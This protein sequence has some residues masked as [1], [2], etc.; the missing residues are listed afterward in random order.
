MRFLNLLL[1][2]VVVFW[3]ALLVRY[4]REWFRY[5]NV[6]SDGHCLFHSLSETG[7]SI[8]DVQVL[9]V[10]LAQATAPGNVHFSGVCC[11]FRVLGCLG[12][13][14]RNTALGL[15]RLREE[16]LTGAWCTD[17]HMFLYSLVTG[18][19]VVCYQPCP[20]GIRKAYDTLDEWGSVVRYCVQTG[21]IP[22]LGVVLSS[23]SFVR[24]IYCHCCIDPQNRDVLSHNHFAKLEVVWTVP[25]TQSV[26]GMVDFVLDAGGSGT[27]ASVVGDEDALGT[28]P[29]IRARYDAVFLNAMMDGLVRGFEEPVAGCDVRES[30]RGEGAEGSG[31]SGCLA[32]RGEALCGDGTGVVDERKRRVTFDEES[33]RKRGRY[34]VMEKEVDFLSEETKKFIG[35]K[36]CL[37]MSE[38]QRRS[39]WYR[40]NRRVILERARAS[41]ERLSREIGGCSG[42]CDT[43]SARG[44]CY[45]IGAGEL[46]RMLEEDGTGQEVFADMSGNPSKAVLLHYLNSGLF[47]FGRWKEYSYE[48]AGQIMDEQSRS[49]LCEEILDEKLT[50]EELK[51]LLE[52]FFKCHSYIEGRLPSC[53][54]CG[55]RM[56]ERPES[57]EIRY[58]CLALTS[59]SVLGPLQYTPCEEVEFRR[60]SYE[61]NSVV[62]IPI[63]DK[64]D[65]RYVDVAKAESVFVDQ[66]E[67]HWHLH[68][69]LVDRDPETGAETTLICPTC[70]ASLKCEK[71]PDL[72]I[73]SGIDFGHYSRLGLTLPNIHE[74]LILSRA[75]LFFA[76]MKFSSNRKGQCNFNTRNRLKCHAILFPSQEADCVPFMTNSDVFGEKGLLDL[77]C[78][79]GM[80]S[81][82]C[83]DDKTNPDY[84]MRLI[85]GSDEIVGRPW[86]LAQWL[87]VL[88]RSNCY[89]GDIDVTGT[90]DFVR[91]IEARMEEVY[92]D[93]S[94]GIKVIN[95]ESALAHEAMLGSD[96]AENQQVEQTEDLEDEDE[97]GMSP[98]S[99]RFSYIAKTEQG[100]Y[101]ENRNDC[102]LLA[103]RKMVGLREEEMEFDGVVES[104]QRNR[105]DDES[106]VI[107]N[108]CFVRGPGEEDAS[109]SDR[110]D[111]SVNTEETTSASSDAT[112]VVRTVHVKQDAGNV[113]DDFAG[114]DQISLFPELNQED[115]GDSVGCSIDQDDLADLGNRVDGMGEDEYQTMPSWDVPDPTDGRIHATAQSEREG[116]PIS[117]FE[118][119]TDYERMMS[120]TFPHVFMLGRWYK[121]HPG[122]LSQKMRHHLLHQF[123]LTPAQDRRLLA[124]LFDKKQRI[125]VL[126]G[127]KAYVGGT[128]RSLEVIEELL[129][130]LDERK[131]LER[132]CK[133]PTSPGSRELL[134]KYMPHL[135][136]A[137]KDVSYGAAEGAKFQWR[138]MEMNKRFS[139]PNCFLTISPTT[140]D[141]PR[142]IRLAFRTVNNSS[143][144]AEFEEGC[145]YG[146]DPEDFIRRL[147][148]FTT[149]VS[150]GFVRLP[151]GCITKAERADLAMRNPVA[152][153]QENKTLLSDILSIL[154]GFSIEDEAF[155]GRNEGESTR[156][157]NYYKSKK[158]IFGHPLYAIGVTEDHHRG[159]LHWHVSLLAGV[160]PY[161][162]QQ[163][164]DLEGV[165]D[166]ISDVLDSMYTSE[167]PENAH[168]GNLLRQALKHH[169]KDE[170]WNISQGVINSISAREPL[171]FTCDPLS[172]LGR[173]NAGEGKTFRDKFQHVAALFGSY[174]QHHRHY[175]TCHKTVRGERGCRFDFP[176]GECEKTRG[177]GLIP[178]MPHVIVGTDS[179]REDVYCLPVEATDPGDT[180]T[181]T[182]VEPLPRKQYR[183]LNQDLLDSTLGDGLVI[184]E[185]K[186]PMIVPSLL[187][188]PAGSSVPSLFELREAFCKALKNLPEYQF[189]RGVHF[190]HWLMKTAT[191][192]QV[193]QLWVEIIRELPLGNRM[194]PSFNTILSYC[195]G[196]HN[197]ASLL[198]GLDQAKSALFYLVPYQGKSKFPIQEALPILNAAL[199]FV[200]QNDSKHPTESGT[201]QRTVK[202]L[203]TRTIN[204]MHL[205]MEI[206]DYEMAASL[207]GLPS[208][209]TSERFAVGNPRALVALRAKLKS[210]HGGIPEVKAFDQLCS[211]ITKTVRGRWVPKDREHFPVFDNVRNTDVSR[212]E[213]IADYGFTRRIP[214]ISE[215]KK[216]HVLVPDVSLYLFRSEELENLSY[217]E[218]IS[219][220]ETRNG[221]A[222]LERDGVRQKR[223]SLLPSFR[224]CND[225][226][227]VL[228][229]KQKT[230][231]FLNAE[232]RHPGPRPDPDD[233]SEDN[234]LSLSQWTVVADEYARYFLTIF[235]PNR[236]NDDD[237]NYSWSALHD[238]IESM[239]ADSS[240]V[241]KFRL[242]IMHQHM[243]GM[244]TKFL[245]K[246]MARD[247]RARS[248]KIWSDQDRF[249]Y[250]EGVRRREKYRNQLDVA[251]L[252]DYYTG[253]E[254]ELSDRQNN[255]MIRQLKHELRQNQQMHKIYGD[256]SQES[257]KLIVRGAVNPESRKKAGIIF[258][259]GMNQIVRSIEGLQRYRTP[260]Q[261][262]KAKVRVPPNFRRDL[263]SKVD[264]I[265]KKLV[266]KNEG[267]G[268]PKNTQQ[269]ELFELYA[270]HFLRE[271]NAERPPQIL[272]C[273]GGP[274]VGKS[275]IR[276]AI[277]DVAEIC[278]NFCLKTSF[279]AINA[280]EMGGNTTA[281]V[282][283]LSSKKHRSYVGDFETTKQSADKIRELRDAGF[284][285]DALVIV[286]EVSN[287]APWHLARLDRLCQEVLG[288]PDRPFGGALVIL[289]GDLTQLGPVKATNLSCGVMDITLAPENRKKMGTRKLQALMKGAIGG[290][291]RTIRSYA[292]DHPHRIGSELFTKVRWFELTQQ[293]RSEDDQ[294]T[295]FVTASY[296][297][298]RFSLDKI[299]GRYRILSKD[300]ARD[301]EWIRAPILV[302]TNR[303][304]QTLTH[305]R[306]I[307]FAKSED[308]VVI[309]W[310]TNCVKWRQRPLLGK[311]RQEALNDP[312]FYEYFVQG[313][314]AF[315]TEN[316]QKDLKMANAAAVVYHSLVLTKTSQVELREKLRSVQPGDVITLSERPV[317]VNVEIQL[318]LET[319]S[320]EVR[321]QY[322]KFQVA[323]PEFTPKK[324]G[325]ET[326][327]LPVWEYSCK[328]D[329]SETTV[330]GGIGFLP[331]KATLKKYFPIEPAFAITVHK[332]EGRTMRR[333]II[334][335]SSCNAR[336]CDFTYAQ[337]H[338][339]FSRVRR[340]EHIRLLLTGDNEAEQW[341]S[342]LYLSG[343][344]P[345]PSIKYYF[346][347]FRQ[348][349][350]YNEPNN[351]WKQNSW[352]AQRANEHI[353]PNRD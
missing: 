44:D 11:A 304:R 309:R 69:E 30:T 38:Q 113:V 39:E 308:T 216:E 24:R 207:L 215:K 31:P 126:D 252:D 318:D 260:V 64:G 271:K 37:R 143:F 68:P 78:L 225:T 168:I 18:V 326:F 273:H 144:P 136:F 278:G 93:L 336:G 280:I 208:V 320:E 238:W 316:I 147:R 219:C 118:E 26:V 291:N 227:Q 96:V 149:V 54:S 285:R 127:V 22:P 20:E 201:M 205:R 138:A 86:V 223:F 61:R 267:M 119:G 92:K 5:I 206:S 27:V 161:A 60:A 203:L 124:Y 139:C 40:A 353:A 171:L 128:R 346:S 212:D 294:H 174:R 2:F 6:P 245:C 340:G 29:E 90:R 65:T 242:M 240:I 322:R 181:Y 257:R 28:A 83:V 296:R 145:K 344:R 114:G 230:P 263:R 305:T 289:I 332:S 347:G 180:K 214:L 251:V 98:Q 229:R 155:F 306:S 35:R 129:D 331:S 50:D 266:I 270:G 333:V 185:T 295:A 248:R 3:M 120:V 264:R 288:V 259:T 268:D 297:G 72:S 106:G 319:T 209:I 112:N 191:H 258:G 286:E 80:L 87:L 140:L 91:R 282:L 345:I 9:R 341:R 313:A 14:D 226:Y 134:N 25:L 123:T 281:S 274:G 88:Q 111:G 10:I 97:G 335:L 200:D 84:L 82:Y 17:E 172:D 276:G 19:R 237:L 158:G 15:S 36:R 141:N 178:S 323:K 137:S 262:K 253:G 189:P 334:A 246:R 53:G 292:A 130:N 41:R 184:W 187:P 235:R 221:T 105:D 269:L 349:Q 298:E 265:R 12:K 193:V 317:A 157:T 224:A 348:I 99:M 198:G 34:G 325:H 343:L 165:C 284:D 58:R 202:H 7:S 67:N 310:K 222:V 312:C 52:R 186:H 89:Y 190:H 330:R 232:P 228:L 175:A 62:C 314:E 66:R 337:V 204:R 102:R 49:E 192:R 142:G 243:R 299:K 197:H 151:G 135:R 321:K 55:I 101:M 166:A 255:N 217:Y 148:E 210:G 81:V 328:R 290:D 47:G 182:V 21:A 48:Y 32:V 70:Y 250:R 162:L 275:V 236:I 247:Y 116:E 194:V 121:K 76:T 179:E 132:A 301:N 300:D 352:S 133:H 338:V 287:Q 75:R 256:M 153:V 110:D 94:K 13:F 107:D 176:C 125:E 279:N 329:S 183:F 293:Q 1:T 231:L 103:M 79:K 122:R 302:S 108:I 254:E 211:L 156:V 74:Q 199:D 261:E 167:V 56:W 220:V 188:V 339:A 234:Q 342:I 272:L 46:R 109:V 233:K 115:T 23:A 213:L 218:Y 4:Q 315:L 150:E 196:S 244:R 160:S 85:H 311:H 73:A 307:Q 164:S 71:R 33:V 8:S 173:M 146:K 177:V 59:D 249:Q 42:V 163:F 131:R 77:S 277:V 95:D 152:F 43:D 239:K 159:T 63:N 241:S 57:P 100:H 154:L 16:L 324:R 327:V 195:T 303:E 104:E 117:E 51:A 170:D 283:K 45:A 350:D 169:K 351:G